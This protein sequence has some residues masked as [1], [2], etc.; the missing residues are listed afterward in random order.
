[1]KTI[2]DRRN[3]NC[4]VAARFCAKNDTPICGTALHALQKNGVFQT[5]QS[6]VFMSF[7]F[8]SG[9]S[10]AEQSARDLFAPMH[11]RN[12]KSPLRA[13]GVSSPLLIGN[14]KEFEIMRRQ[15]SKEEKRKWNERYWSKKR[16]AGWKFY[17]FCLPQS[18]GN[19]ILA[20]KCQRMAE[21]KQAL[22]TGVE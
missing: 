10:P 7:P 9:N 20:L 15:Y 1:M 12:I 5:P 16:R 13:F 21:Y 8:S 17:G 6:Y 18:I 4:G 22:E 11:P 3:R 19:E 14:K 2:P